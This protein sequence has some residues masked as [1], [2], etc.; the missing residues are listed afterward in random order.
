MSGLE[1]LVPIFGNYC[2]PGWSDGHRLD[3][4]EI[5]TFTHPPKELLG[6]DGVLRPSPPDVLC[7]AHDQAYAAAVG[8]P[9]E[10]Q[11]QLQADI[12]LLNG[13]AAMDWSGLSAL[14]SA[15]SGLMAVAFVAKIGAVDIPGTI[16]ENIKS[17]AISTWDG[18]KNAFNPVGQ[19]YADANGNSF[20]C[21]ADATGNLA[22]NCSTSS[23]NPNGTRVPIESSTFNLNGQL[24][25][26]TNYDAP[27]TVSVTAD[28]TPGQSQV[29]SLN[30]IYDNGTSCTLDPP[31][32]TEAELAGYGLYSMDGIGGRIGQ[33]G[34]PGSGAFMSGGFAALSPANAKLDQNAFT[35]GGQSYVMGN[36]LTDFAAGAGQGWNS[37][38]S[39]ATPGAYSPLYLS[40]RGG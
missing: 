28:F 13:I 38:G 17:A 12:N 10:Y 39:G 27:G 29:E 11:L 40:L 34:L 2:G 4:G 26:R 32:L 19:S 20:S 36:S 3:P 24:F 37:Q 30:V 14:E 35:I 1:L 6:P 31:A 9:N 16:Y 22:L 5:P 33:L 21:S 18:I 23:L 7:L 15:Y 8:S 25:K